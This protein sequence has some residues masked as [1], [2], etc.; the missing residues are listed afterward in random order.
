MFRPFVRG[1]VSFGDQ[2]SWTSSARLAGA[3]DGAGSFDTDVPVD[4]VVARATAGLQ[5]LNNGEVNVRAQYD[6]EFSDN[7]TSHGGSIRVNFAL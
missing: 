5:I 2:S 6:G 4:D 7:I 1:G 3:P